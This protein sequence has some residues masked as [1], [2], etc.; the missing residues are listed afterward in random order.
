MQYSL[1]IIRA[2]KGLVDG[3]QQGTHKNVQWS[4]TT[5]TDEASVPLNLI[6][7]RI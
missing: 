6:P 1:A 3:S 7:L 2:V 5:I 4:D